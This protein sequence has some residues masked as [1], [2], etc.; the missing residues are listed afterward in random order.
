[1]HMCF[2]VCVYVFL[3]EKLRE[4]QQLSKMMY[5]MSLGSMTEML[6]YLKGIIS[7]LLATMWK[8]VCRQETSTR[9]MASFLEL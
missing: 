3:L 6:A 7:V 1:M 2:H 5:L 4:P 9:P 8:M